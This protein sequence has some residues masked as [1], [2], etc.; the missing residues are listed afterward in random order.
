MVH[1]SLIILFIFC[2][3][4][5][6]KLN[7]FDLKK[8]YVPSSVIVK[9]G[10]KLD[11]IINLLYENQIIKNKFFFKLWVKVYGVETKLKFG[12]FSFE[13]EINIHE[14]TKKLLSGKSKF[15]K[16]TI[17]EGSSKFDLFHK[18]SEI[19]KNVNFTIEDIPEYLVANTY[20]YQITDSA[21]RILENITK[22][23]LDISNKIWLER[24]TSISLTTPKE[25]FI[26]ASIVEKETSIEDEKPKIAGV[27]FNR[28]KKKMRLQSDPT[29]V[30]SI[31]GGKKKLGRKLYRKDL[32]FESEFNTYR[33]LGLPPQPICFPGID[34]LI[35]VSKP[36][37]SELLYFVA[38]NKNGEHYFSTNYK[39]HLKNVKAVKNEKN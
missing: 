6:S 9:P 32:K 14:I 36:L 17:I 20:N 2:L 27:F 8:D 33:N 38:K 34:S 39:D 22:T 11:E 1:K 5:F 3:L 18:L 31:T 16:L 25:L 29:V 13:N 30:F 12:E 28:L 35:S 21:K 7:F 10:M 26:L 23:S 19:D 37:K 24:D 4:N 15:R